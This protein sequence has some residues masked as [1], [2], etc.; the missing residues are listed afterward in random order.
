MSTQ[1]AN[2]FDGWDTA[3][4]V[5]QYFIDHAD[6]AHMDT[7]KTL[8][9]KILE[10]TEGNTAVADYLSG[11]SIMNARA[12]SAVSQIQVEDGMLPPSTVLELLTQLVLNFEHVTW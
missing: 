9:G 1:Y 4:E 6:A 11:I 3:I 2:E 12:A 5:Y 7:I 10:Q 8:R